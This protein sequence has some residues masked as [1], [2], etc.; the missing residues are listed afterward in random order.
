VPVARRLLAGLQAYTLA[1]AQPP[2]PSTPTQVAFA[3][4]GAAGTQPATFP[5]AQLALQVRPHYR[6]Y[7]SALHSALLCFLA[8]PLAEATGAHTTVLP[9]L[10]L[11]T[12]GHAVRGLLVSLADG[13]VSTPGE[14]KVSITA[15]V[16]GCCVALVIELA[17]LPGGGPDPL[18]LRAAGLALAPQLARLRSTNTLD[19]AAEGRNNGDAAFV[20]LAIP[21]A[22]LA[23]LS[24]G[25]VVLPA[26]RWAKAYWLATCPPPGVAAF[27]TPPAA[28]TALLRLS[29]MLTAA[30]AALPY[31]AAQA[32]SSSSFIA[33]AAA[34]DASLLPL[35]LVL[36]A[37]THLLTCRGAAQSSLDGALVAWYQLRHVT[38]VDA[39]LAVQ[40]MTAKFGKASSHLCH[41]AMLHAG[42][43]QLLLAA[44][45]IMLAKRPGVAL[46]AAKGGGNSV[47]APEVY[48]AF[49]GFLG[50]W[51][52]LVWTTAAFVQLFAL[53]QGLARVG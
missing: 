3:T 2:P 18:R 36:A 25:L 23:G 32:F 29:F 40:V 37:A 30:C 4:Q 26:A 31:F 45:T 11:L 20:A 43:A 12:A 15:G 5:I 14:Q 1:D 6:L 10:A 21:L 49:F 47:F 48:V 28:H 16:C 34:H 8:L 39:S 24:A 44:G 41:A 35:C 53:R 38:G 46:D 52:A 19:G 27:T 17:G 7:T 51:T 22:L 42:P 13:R 50:A 33:H 9:L